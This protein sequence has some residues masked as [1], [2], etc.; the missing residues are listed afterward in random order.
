MTIRFVWPVACALLLAGSALAGTGG[1]TR[2]PGTSVP[3]P[4]AL[5]LLGIGV[6]GILAIRH[7]GKKT[8][9]GAIIA[10]AAGT[11]V[12]QSA[13]IQGRRSRS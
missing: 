2:P 13:A 10:T 3:E 12:T 6:A 1:S 7:R 8:D 9:R 5:A 11:P 4:A